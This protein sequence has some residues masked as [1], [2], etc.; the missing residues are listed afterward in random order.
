MLLWNFTIVR[1]GRI[2]ET[3]LMQAVGCRSDWGHMRR[4]TLDR[5]HI[6][7]RKRDQRFHNALRA[8]IAEWYHHPRCQ[9]ETT[10]SYTGKP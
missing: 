4:E 6:A 3:H 1:F 7:K 9:T 8:K 10:R 2:A 5:H